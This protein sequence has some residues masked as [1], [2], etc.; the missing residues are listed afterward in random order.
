[1]NFTTCIIFYILVY[2]VTRFDIE[3][4]LVE[5]T[6]FTIY[7]LVSSIFPFVIDWMEKICKKTKEL[8]FWN[9]GIFT[10]RLVLSVPL[11]LF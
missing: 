4:N 7:G 8:T 5:G 9:N 11:G 2:F 10:L 6:A 3:I 1:M